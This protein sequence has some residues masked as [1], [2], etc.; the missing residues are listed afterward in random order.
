MKHLENNHGSTFGMKHEENWK[1]KTI[2]TTLIITIVLLA[3]ASMVIGQHNEKIIWPAY[4]GNKERTG[5]IPNKWRKT[6]YRYID[7]TIKWKYHANLCIA[8]SPVIAD[9][10]N[11]GVPDV[12]FASCDGYQYAVNA[13]TGKLEWK[14]RT[15]GGLVSPEAAD[16]DNNGVIEVIVGGAT[17]NL[18]AINGENGRIEWEVKGTFQRAIPEITD[19]NNNGEKEVVTTSMSGDLYIINAKGN[20]TRKIRCGETALSPPT[21][22]EEKGKTIILTTD[23]HNLITIDTSNWSIRKIRIPE[24]LVGAP[25]VVIKEKSE[26][27]LIGDSHIY[28]VNITSQTIKWKTGFQGSGIASPSIGDALNNNQTQILVGTDHGLYVYSMNGTLIT[29]YHDVRLGTAPPIIIDLDNDGENEVL[30]GSYDG[31][32]IIAQLNNHTSIA[33]AIKWEYQTNAPIMAPPAIGDGDN[34]GSPEVYWGSRDYNLYCI[35]G[36]QANKNTTIQATS[37]ATE[38]T[39][40]NNTTSTT[41]INTTI[42]AWVIEVLTAITIIIYIWY[43]KKR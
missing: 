35:D 30:L 18:Y 34:D 43:K 36:V 29:V 9:L 1:K 25:P 32:L 16:L 15:G 31:E 28:M 11:D 17:G 13:A 38:T 19:I 40:I 21:L 4:K 7:Y 33:E 5:Y 6:S 8:S 10:N 3:T 20:I 39:T 26:A 22:Y 23:D 41:K 2:L 24:H 12:S 42:L 37:N 14:V 27:L